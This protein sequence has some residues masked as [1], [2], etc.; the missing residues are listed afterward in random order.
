MGSSGITALLRPALGRSPLAYPAAQWRHIIGAMRRDEAV[1][2]L[3]GALLMASGALLFASGT[4]AA[5]PS[6]ALCWQS[7]APDTG[8]QDLGLATTEPA[9]AS[10]GPNEVWL[11]LEERSPQILRWKQGLW[12]RVPLPER[13]G[14]EDMG[15]PV[16]A[17]APSGSVVIAFSANGKDGTS[18]L[19]IARASDGSW[20]WLG[21]PLISSKEPWT[22]AQDASI[23]FL[24]GGHPVVAWS[25]ERHV[26]L[27]GLF[28]ARWNGSSWKRLGALSPGGDDY[29]LSPRVAVDAKKQIWLSWNEARSGG[30]RVV[31]WNGAAWRDI[32][33]EALQK[34]AAAQ[35]STYQPSLVVDDKGRAWLLWLASK[36]EEGASLVLARWDGAHW[37]SVP[38]PR[39]PGGKDGTAWH[40]SMMLRSGAPIVAWSQ[41]DETDNRRLYVSE[42]LA[43]DRWSARLSGLHLVEGVSNVQDVRLA[44]GDDRSFFVSWDEGG[45]DKRRTRLVRAYT[46]AA[47]ETPAPPPKS[48]VE[49]DTWPT[50]VDEAA[51]RIASEM[52]DESKARVRATKKD[53]LI[54]YHH[55]WGTGIRNSLGL[56]RGNVKLS[57]SCGQGKWVH[58]DDCSMIIIEAVWSLL[59][60]PS[61]PPKSRD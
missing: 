34:L 60:G 15:Y 20:E 6:D 36:R 8:A 55:G 16:V 29:Y 3:C 48:L 58:P 40:A 24:E 49:R 53:D 27:A 54:R 43:G 19:H 26:K 9:L 56:W 18:A 17:A 61:V 2:A 25:E 37:T 31:R 57:E 5:A 42:W 21:E 33:R 39:A 12:S 35:G 1:S 45:K 28:V 22:H 59:Q 23:A 30:L 44:A 38:T 41:V 13:P 4:A 14:A 10:T 50:T 52:N 7:L 51:R 47:G 46:C 32:G 11:S